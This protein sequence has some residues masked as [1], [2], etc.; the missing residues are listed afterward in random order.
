MRNHPEG[1]TMLLISNSGDNGDCTA[2]LPSY[3]VSPKCLVS[4]GNESPI[5]TDG[6]DQGALCQDMIECWLVLPLLTTSTPSLNPYSK[7]HRVVSSPLAPGEL[8]GGKKKNK[9]KDSK[10]LVLVQMRDKSCF[11]KRYE[12][13]ER[14][15]CFFVH[16]YVCFTTSGRKENLE[17]IKSTIGLERIY[18]LCPGPRIKPQSIMVGFGIMTGFPQ[19]FRKI[20]QDASFLSLFSIKDDRCRDFLARA[21]TI[22]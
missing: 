19:K 13:A 12:P 2:V 6:P 15:F 8:S 21:G 9:N 20:W 1:C 10:F 18:I 11:E 16:E 7:R 5:W 3:E 22:R 4:E 17:R 14:V